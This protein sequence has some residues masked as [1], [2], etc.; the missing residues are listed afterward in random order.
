V[1]RALLRKDWFDPVASIVLPAA[2]F[3]RPAPKDEDGLSLDIDSPQSCVA[4]FNRTY[5]V[6]SL[7]VGRIRDVQLDVEIDEAPHANIIR[8]PR[9]EE[10]LAQ[11]EFLAGQL[12]RQARYI[13]PGNYQVVPPSSAG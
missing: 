7:H 5:G 4:S 3:R 10:E 12:A 9:K 11:A 13:A 8:L 1:Y 2:F 6:A